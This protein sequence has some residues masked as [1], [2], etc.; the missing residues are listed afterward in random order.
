VPLHG[1]HA[2]ITFFAFL[3]HLAAFVLFCAAIMARGGWV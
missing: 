1:S 3:H 2:M